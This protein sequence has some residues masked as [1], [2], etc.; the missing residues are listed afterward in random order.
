M[1]M[2]IQADVALTAGV[3]GQAQVDRL[4]QSLKRTGDIAQDS[5]RRTAA[6]MGQLPMQLN[7]L[8]VQIAGGQNP[9]MALFQQGTQVRDAFGGI[10]PAMRAIGSLITPARVAFGGLAAVVGTT[11]AAFVA[12]Q[13]EASALSKSLALSG[14]Q[15]GITAG[16]FEAMAARIRG[17]TGATAGNSRD[18]LAGAAGTGAFG[19]GTIETATSAMARLQRLSGQ[20]SE[21]IVKDFA[22]MRSG[23]AQW[24]AEHNR[25]YA[26]L[27]EATFRQ[28]RALE[29]QGKT[30]EAL[31]LN[32]EALDRALAGREV[33]LGTLEKLW[34][35][36]KEAASGAWDAMKG[37]GRPDSTA[38]QMAALQRDLQM[39]LERGPLNSLTGA[40]FEKGNQYLR[41]Q[42]EL[43]RERLV[44]EGRQASAQ[45]ASAAAERKAIDDIQSGFNDRMAETRLAGIM[46]AD[47]LA[48]EARIKG[49]EMERAQIER[50]QAAGLI[51]EQTAA[52]RRLDIRQRELAEQAVL[53]QREIE[54]EKMRPVTGDPRL[55]GAQQANRLAALQGRLDGLRA[56]S[57]IE[58]VLGSAEA[59][60]ARVAQEKE[61]AKEYA[62]A[63]KTANDFLQRL[64]QQNERGAAALL[65]DPVDRARAEIEIAVRE[66]ERQATDAT[67]ALEFELLIESDPAQIERIKRQLAEIQ[68]A[69]AGAVDLERAKMPGS[70]TWL[71][72]LAQGFGEWRASALDTAG[73][74]KSAFTSMA[75]GIEDALVQWVTTGKA[76]FKDFARSVI[77]D[78]TRIIIRWTALQAVQ[79]IMGAFGGGGAAPFSPNNYGPSA[80]PAFAKGG[81]FG[82]SIVSSP[83][84]FKFAAGG[85]MRNGLMGEAG[86]EAIMPLRRTSSGDLGVQVAGGAGGITIGSIVVQDGGATARDASG[87]NAEQLGRALAGAVQAEIIRQKRPGGLLAAA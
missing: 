50:L 85:T 25:Q 41:D 84:L 78:I 17:A 24:A 61:A 23:V 74:I 34:L 60:K 81:A 7:D 51:G 27:T 30:E 76:S 37:V 79:G 75:S 80:V 26:Y 32:V 20:S 72:G 56:Q 33:Q 2:K 9:L 48:S 28:I 64:R 70:K 29:Q 35:G 77:A 4:N 12:G 55:F 8:A 6:A 59:T 53:V 87:Q 73:A 62:D 43:L 21:E 71:Q 57:G 19:P 68:A 45:A 54:L 31:R 58:A 38:D 39:R 3:S 11:V 44:L 42:I 14:N 13:A 22:K 49:L 82:G 1:T 83:T 5:G 10:G 69:A 16:Q 18:L 63:W 36:V 52:D 47:K 15:A 40:A 46:Q 67:K 86:P 66:I 65:A